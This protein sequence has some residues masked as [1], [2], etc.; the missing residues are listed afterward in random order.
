MGTLSS[1]AYFT[2]FSL[3]VFFFQASFF[4]LAISKGSAIEYFFHS[5]TMLSTD[6]SMH[7]VHIHGVC[8]QIVTPTVHPSF[9][10]YFFGVFLSF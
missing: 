1:D 7:V 9:F 3:G 2:F 4:T 6:F 5:L 8:A 10:V